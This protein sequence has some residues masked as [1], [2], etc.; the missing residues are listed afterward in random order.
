[1]IDTG[2]NPHGIQ[3]I[4]ADIEKRIRFSHNRRAQDFLPDGGQ[5]DF[6]IGIR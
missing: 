6:R 1:M 3:G 4:A 2:Q 5:P